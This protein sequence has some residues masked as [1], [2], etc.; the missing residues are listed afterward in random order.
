MIEFP[1]LT[2]PEFAADPYSVYQRLREQD[3]LVRDP[4]TGSYLLSRYDECA[5]AFRDTRFTSR[6]YEWQLEPVHGRTILQMDGSE[7]ARRRALLNP[8]FRGKGLQSWLPYMVD[9]ADGL[10]A[11]L[12]EKHA[13]ARL[14]RLAAQ[15]SFDLVADFSRKYPIDVMAEMLGLPKARHDDF[16]RWYLSIV[17]FLSNLAEDPDVHADGLRTRRELEEYILPLVAERRGSGGSDLISKLA[18][19]DVDG[20]PMSDAEVKAFVSLLLTAGGETTDKTFASAVSNLL[21]HPDQLGR[22][23]GNLDLV[24]AAIA[25]TL[26]Y[27]PPTHM[28]MR[29]VSEEVVVRETVI[30]AGSRVI[31]LNGSAN[32]DEA[33]FRAAHEFRVGRDD[34]TVDNAFSGAADHVAF[35][36]GRHFCVG[37]MLARTELDVALRALFTRFPEMRLAPGF[38][39]R[40]IGSKTRGLATL[41]VTA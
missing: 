30:P 35:G 7:H 39:P 34:L 15:S 37:A 23:R 16:R 24:P 8:F 22:V 1:G 41:L 13:S 28:T 20:E 21:Q 6:N 18:G 38:V 11:A 4:D 36:G 12:S 25:E 2:S 33:R 40:E 9:L 14:D 17:A 10:V 3:R 32:R 27:S 26:R 5:A 19:S 31:V 29:E